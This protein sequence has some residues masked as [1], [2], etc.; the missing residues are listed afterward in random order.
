MSRL[1]GKVAVITGGSSG[2]GWRPLE[3]LSKKAGMSS[4]PG[5]ARASWTRPKRLSATA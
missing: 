1:D 5:A 2:I 4:S 3:G